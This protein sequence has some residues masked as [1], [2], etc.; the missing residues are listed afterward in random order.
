MTSNLIAAWRAGVVRNCDAV[1]VACDWDCLTPKCSE[2]CRFRDGAYC[3][4]NGEATAHGFCVEALDSIARISVSE[5][6][7]ENKKRMS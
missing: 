5:F 4:A 2:K 7:D 3:S 6:R 1:D